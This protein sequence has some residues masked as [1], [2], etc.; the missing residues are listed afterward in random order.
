MTAIRR[1]KQNFT[2]GE[3]S[4]KMDH[5]TEFD[6]L[7]NGCRT[8]RNAIAEVQGA[9]TNRPGTQFIYSLNDLGLDTDDPQVRE[10]PFVFSETQ[11][12]MMIFFMH[13]SGVPR[14]VFGYGDGLVVGS[15][16]VTDP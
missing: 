12:Y 11:N 2:A 7:K 6:R 4:P 5:L 15:T 8:L 16:P 14:V 1:L 3:I 10:V 9:A 13:T